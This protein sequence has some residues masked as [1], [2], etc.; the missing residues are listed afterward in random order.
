MS[1]LQ[2]MRSVTL[3]LSLLGIVLFL[4]GIP[5]LYLEIRDHCIDQVCKAFYNPPPGSAWLREQGLT[6]SGYALAY[7]SLYAVVGGAYLTAAGILYWKQSREL[8]GLLGTLM[9][10]LLG[11]TFTPIL[12]GLRDQHEVLHVLISLI[13]A[14]GFTAFLLF[15]YLFPTGRFAPSWSRYLMIG[16][17]IIGLPKYL[18]PGSRVDLQVLSPAIYFCWL[19]LWIASLILNQVYR[20]R[21]VSH[22]LE[23]QQTKWVVYGVSLALLGLVLFTVVYLLGEERFLKDPYLM[24]GLELGIQGSMLLIPVALVI[25]VLKS[26]LWD[27]DPLVNRTLLYGLLTLGV[28]LMY[29]V[30]VWY[31]GTAFQASHWLTSLMATSIIAVSFAPLKERLQRWINKLMYGEAVDPYSVLARLGKRLE[32]PLPPE[33]ALEAVVKTVRSALRLPYA[34]IVLYRGGEPSLVME[35]GVPPA[36]AEAEPHRAP[37]VHRG[38]LLGDLLAAPRL[39]GEAFTASDL[40]LL[41]MLVQQASV[42]VDNARVTLDLT[43]TSAALRESRERLV[44]ARE[45]ERKQLRRDLHDNLAPRLASMAL[46]ASA[47]EELV[48]RDPAAAKQ[49]VAELRS[50]IRAT[51]GDIRELVYSMRPPALDELGLLGALGERVRELNRAAAG[52]SFTLEVPEALPPLPAA[53][54]VAAF[55]IATEAMVNALRHSGAKQCIVRLAYA[56]PPG[57]EPSGE[58]ALALEIQDDGD[59]PPLPRHRKEHRSGGVGLSSMRERAEEL[60]GSFRLQPLQPKGTLITASLP[61][62][63]MG[64]EETNR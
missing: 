50:V 27:I 7:V 41:D 15:F 29:T 33:E 32:D 40:K 44:L 1:R 16:I 57:A 56:E 60:G 64:R 45:E 37:L 39:A 34:A 52:L 53:V 54:E 49:L 24:Y 5:E 28:I 35:D 21:R 30:T 31:L 63:G 13:A 6:P 17:L 48:D 12:D 36:G 43:R 2:A 59:G 8:M 14:A 11:I 9:L 42:V 47:A 3:W 26:R 55:R 38:E 51:V 10:V 23:R 4:W 62:A 61:V 46:T 20:Y 19:V 22:P 25:A 18:F 58:A